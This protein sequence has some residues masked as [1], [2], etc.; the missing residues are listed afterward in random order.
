MKNSLKS[1]SE[2]SLKQMALLAFEQSYNSVVITSADV[3]NP[4]FIYVNPAFTRQ[5]GYTF[6]EVIGK[7]PKILQGEKTDRA[8]I[9]RLK[10]S[11]KERSFFQGTTINY[12][13]DGTEYYVEWNISPVFDTKGEL[14]YFVSFQ[15]DISN[16]MEL[17]EKDKELLIQQSKLASVGELMNAMAHQWK[18]PLAAIITLSQMLLKKLKKEVKKEDLQSGLKIIAEQGVFMNDTISSFQNFLRPVDLNRSFNVKKSIEDILM[19]MKD[20]LMGSTIAVEFSCLQDNIVVH[21]SEN[22]FKQV[23]LN[24]LANA[25][26]AFVMQEIASSRKIDINVNVE[27]SCVRIDV[28]DN[29]GGI[30]ISPIEKVFENNMSTKGDKGTGIGLYIVKQIV[31]RLKGTI[32][33]L[34]VGD[35]STKFSIQLPVKP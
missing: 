10:K 5:T 22:E 34:L 20:Q 26:D 35:G 30:K 33:V 9:D 14:A 11:L 28:I 16:K 6:E 3:D 12:K 23:I 18:Q 8:V 15:I 24:L 1:I 32:D 31:S 2:A 21:G 7:N 29:A 19:L 27:D 4:L 25:K 17:I 13:K